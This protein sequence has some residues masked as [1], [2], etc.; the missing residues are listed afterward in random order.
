M[1]KEAI[2]VDIVH[3][4]R[5]TKSKWLFMNFKLGKFEKKLSPINQSK[6]FENFPYSPWNI[7]FEII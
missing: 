3:K 4:H 2:K 6:Q 7:L 1:D 5:G